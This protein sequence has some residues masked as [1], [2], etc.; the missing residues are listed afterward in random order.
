MHANLGNQSE[1]QKLPKF[2]LGPPHFFFYLARSHFAFV[3]CEFFS[4]GPSLIFFYRPSRQF[5]SWIKI[6]GWCAFFYNLTPELV[7][8]RS[9]FGR[10]FLARLCARKGGLICKIKR[11][12]RLGCGLY[13]KIRGCILLFLSISSFKLCLDV[14]ILLF[15]FVNLMLICIS[16]PLRRFDFDFW[17]GAIWGLRF[18]D[19]SRI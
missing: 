10:R 14:E 12:K 2:R 17:T 13:T 6:R 1:E 19:V 11:C 3:R 15:Y 16:T 7:I 9:G 18:L 8:S 4:W 5:N